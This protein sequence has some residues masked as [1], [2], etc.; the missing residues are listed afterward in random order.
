MLS[1][2][3]ALVHFAS[4]N[5]GR[6]TCPM[7]SHAKQC[8][9]CPCTGTGQPGEHDLHS[10]QLPPVVAT[11]GQ[12]ALDQAKG[13]LL[14]AR[15]TNPHYASLP[16]LMG[17]TESVDSLKWKMHADML[18]QQGDPRALQVQPLLLHAANL[19]LHHVGMSVT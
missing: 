19:V 3:A 2:P 1:V 7:H 4:T 18:L 16:T 10:S 5:A 15:R 14:N 17:Q 6:V 13:H 8:L 12:Q 9:A 11:P